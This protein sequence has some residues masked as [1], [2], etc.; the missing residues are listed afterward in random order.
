ML[1]KLMVASTY[2]SW[3]FTY[4]LR[5]SLHCLLHSPVSFT[6]AW[7]AL[8]SCIHSTAVETVFISELIAMMWKQ[9]S[10][11]LNEEAA[12]LYVGWVLTPG[13]WCILHLRSASAALQTA[14][15]TDG[16]LLICRNHISH[17]L[18]IYFCTSSHLLCTQLQGQPVPGIWSY[19]NNTV[20]LPM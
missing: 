15:D 6:P 14:G 2:K 3:I 17:F 10:H 20:I 18:A 9:I 7:A 12:V 5:I 19:L 11:G 1:T 4:W 13:I 8:V 16:S